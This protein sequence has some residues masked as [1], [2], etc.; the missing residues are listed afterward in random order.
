MQ[1]SRRLVGSEVHA[2]AYHVRSKA[3][4]ARLYGANANS[5][6]ANRTVLEVTVDRVSDRARTLLPG[7]WEFTPTGNHRKLIKKLKICKIK[8]WNVVEQQDVTVTNLEE[9]LMTCRRFT[10]RQ[11]SD[12]TEL[13]KFETSPAAPAKVPNTL[14]HGV[15]WYKK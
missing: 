14:V 13:E 10:C 6:S 15:R 4:C 3:E 11:P 5:K 9:P 7:E 2:K 8:E 1:R 12:D